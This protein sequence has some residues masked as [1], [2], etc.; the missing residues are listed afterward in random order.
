[1]PESI[2]QLAEALRYAAFPGAGDWHTADIRVK[3][4]WRAAA[5]HAHNYMDRERDRA[6]RRAVGAAHELGDHKTAQAIR[7]MR[8]E[9]ENG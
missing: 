8:R 7:V 1:M 6:L 3:E 2:D 9:Y 4:Q 5:L